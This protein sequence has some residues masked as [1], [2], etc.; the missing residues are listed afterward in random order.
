MITF[1]QFLGMLSRY[2]KIMSLDE[3]EQT[4]KDNNNEKEE[5]YLDEKKEEPYIK[6]ENASFCWGYKQRKN[7]E[8]CDREDLVEVKST[9]KPVI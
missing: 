6:L 4:Q 7:T 8:L 2:S 9:R 3:K 1:Q 5:K